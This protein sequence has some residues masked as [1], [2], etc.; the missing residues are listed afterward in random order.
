MKFLVKKFDRYGWNAKPDSK[1]AF[2]KL[3]KISDYPASPLP[4]FAEDDDKYF[5]EDEDGFKMEKAVALAGEEAEEE[6]R[7]K[8]VPPGPTRSGD[9]AEAE[10]RPAEKL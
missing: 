5:V 10:D 3:I 4:L 8:S 6:E 1:A 7:E 2:T 9:D